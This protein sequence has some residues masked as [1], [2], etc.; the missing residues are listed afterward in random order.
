MDTITQ[1]FASQRP[2]TRCPAGCP[3]GIQIVPV[4]G[5]HDRTFPV[6]V[7]Y[8]GRDYLNGAGEVTGT[9]VWLTYAHAAEARLWHAEGV[10]A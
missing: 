4:A 8:H 6:F 10:T 2:A 7:A 3:Q 9:P 1:P 5:N